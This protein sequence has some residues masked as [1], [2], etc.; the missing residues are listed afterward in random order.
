MRQQPP[1]RQQGMHFA[2]LIIGLILLGGTATFR[3][4][5]GWSWVDS[6]YF[7]GASVLTIG[8]GD[9]VPTTDLTKILVVVFGFIAIGT[10]LYAVSV[11]GAEVSGRLHSLTRSLNPL[12]GFQEKVEPPRNRRGTGRKSA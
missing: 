6:F 4:L 8:Y 11:V 9:L 12:N 1:S 7:T 5:E 2:G 10:F 3:A